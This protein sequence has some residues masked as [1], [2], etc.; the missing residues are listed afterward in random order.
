[1]VAVSWRRSCAKGEAGDA[2]LDESAQESL[3][4]PPHPRDPGGELFA[5]CD[6]GP[7]GQL[8]EINV[9]A[10]VAQ[11]KAGHGCVAQAAVHV[12]FDQKFPAVH[13]AS[14]KDADGTQ[15]LAALGALAFEGE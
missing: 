6:L 9:R 5:P 12:E 4:Q 3:Q 11:R 2:A 7:V 10:M 15:A 8:G 13:G 1:L 14:A